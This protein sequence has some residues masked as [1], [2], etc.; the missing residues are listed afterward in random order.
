MTEQEKDSLTENLDTAAG[1]EAEAAPA[2]PPMPDP[3][4]DDVPRSALR[5]AILVWGVLCVL[6][7]NP[8]CSMLGI[9][10]VPMWVL[11]AIAFVCF[12][13]AFALRDKGQ[14]LW[15][16]LWPLLPFAAAVVWSFL[17]F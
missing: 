9:A 16:V 5:S 13:R 2:A 1:D 17:P 14:Y 11:F 7:L 4:S 8:V 12:F 10:G 6:L 15:A 3:L